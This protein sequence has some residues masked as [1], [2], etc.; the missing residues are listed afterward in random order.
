MDIIINL[1]KERDITSQQAVTRIKRLFAAK[2]AGH[3]GTLD[4]IATGILLICLNEAT[5]V[6]RFLSDLDKE[7]IVRLKLGES[8]DTYDSTGRITGRGKISSLSLPFSSIDKV[9][10]R[11]SGQI[12]QVP[13]MYSAIKVAGQPL[14]KF[15]RQ[16]REIERPP[17]KI[18]VYSIDLLEIYLPYIEMKVACSK[19]TY[20]RTLC[21]DIGNA[22]GV[23]AHMDSLKRTRIGHFKIADAASGEEIQLKKGA[24]HSIDS[25]LSHLREVIFD[26]TSF[27]R[28]RN[29]LPVNAPTCLLKTPEEEISEKFFSERYVR[30][31]SPDNKLFGIGKIND[32]KV[33]IERLLN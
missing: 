12:E 26:E 5:K 31:K 13:P 30:L 9:L 29:G 10:N 21:H 28:A 3:A 24:Q 4:P 14:Y 8:T 20:V 22:L 25:A 6:A 7:Y 18:T 32:K 11:F 17:R 23:G 19:G 15:A 16:G 2:K 1:D 27:H 33:K